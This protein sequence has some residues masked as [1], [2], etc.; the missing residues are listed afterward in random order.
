MARLNLDGETAALLAEPA[1]T[2]SGAK[3]KLP[4]GAFLQASREAEAILAAL[5][6][7]GV[8]K[9]K[10][11]ADLFAGIGTFTFALA[12]ASEVDAFEEDAAALDALAQAV[13]AT[14]KLKPVRTHRRDLFRAPLSPR[15]LG[16]Y[17]AVVLDPPRAGSRAQA[18]AL[19]GSKVKRIVM[20]SC[21]PATCARDARILIDGGYRLSRIVPVDQF[22]FSPH[23]ELVALLER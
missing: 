2:L 19:A 13:R 8:G 4:P 22:L 6:V 9:A 17:D 14:P 3:V 23:I 12:R 20:V 5:V 18:E 11:V 15:E 10:H 1:V 16:S 7:E 21:N